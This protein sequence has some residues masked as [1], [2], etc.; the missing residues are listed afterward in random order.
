[1]HKS[2]DSWNHVCL[3]FYVFMLL[4]FC[5][6]KLLGLV[7]LV[8]VYFLSLFYRFFSF[9]CFIGSHTSGLLA[10][11]VT[12]KYIWMMATM[13]N[14]MVVLHRFLLCSRMT[15][16]PRR[17]WWWSVASPASGHVG[18]CPPPGVWEKKISARLYVVWFGMVLCKTLNLEYICSAIF[19][20]EW[21]HNRV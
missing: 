16:N 14:F 10:F 15:P 21:Y 19:A 11:M 1:M 13:T 5:V 2:A 6:T 12:F 3:W 18:T 8:Y 17:R 9:C 7:A 20:L 4:W